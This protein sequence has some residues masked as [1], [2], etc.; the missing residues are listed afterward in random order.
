[1]ILSFKILAFLAIVCFV[2][3][4]AHNTKNA[5]SKFSKM[6]TIRGGSNS[7]GKHIDVDIIPDSFLSETNTDNSER[8]RAKVEA[9]CRRAQVS[10]S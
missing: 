1:M 9:I 5:F 6:L 2:V 7:F 3:T 8:M 10:P 4:E